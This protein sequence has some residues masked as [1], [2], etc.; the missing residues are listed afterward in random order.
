MAPHLLAF[1]PAELRRLAVV[2]ILGL[3]GRWSPPSSGSASGVDTPA[4]A[5]VAPPGCGQGDQEYEFHYVADEDSAGFGRI[6]VDLL[7]GLDRRGAVVEHLV[8]HVVPLSDG[9]CR[10][11]AH[12]V[13]RE[14]VLSLRGYDRGEPLP[15]RRPRG[16]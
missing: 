8:T 11:V 13:S 5:A 2:A 9:R 7:A 3:A 14:A 15:S 10:H 12:V 6:L 16:S 1:S 4:P